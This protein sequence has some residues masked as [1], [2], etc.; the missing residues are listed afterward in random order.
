MKYKQLMYEDMDFLMPG[1]KEKMANR[2]RPGIQH[3]ISLFFTL[4]EVLLVLLF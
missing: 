1:Y 2:P 4:T 3:I